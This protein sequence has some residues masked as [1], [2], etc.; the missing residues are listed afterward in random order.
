MDLTR[1]AVKGTGGHQIGRGARSHQGLQESNLFTSHLSSVSFDSLLIAANLIETC[2]EQMKHIHAQLNLDSL[3]PGK[4]FQRKKDD[5]LS[6]ELKLVMQLLRNCFFQNENC[7]AAALGTH[8]I[9][10]LHSLWPWL[11]MDDSL[12]QTA[13]HLLCVYT[14]NYPSGCGSLC[15]SSSGLSPLQTA[16]RTAAGNSLM[17][18]IVK[19]ASQT[20]AENSVIQ[21]MTFNLLANL[22][23]SH[24]CKGILQKNNF[25]QNF[26]SVSLPKGGNKSL[27]SL[28]VAWLKLLLNLSFG[29]DGQ[30]MIVKLNGSLDQLIEM[31][32]FK[33]RSNPN[34]I[35]LIVHNICFNPANKPKILANDKAIS[36][37]S[38]CL[39][40]D[41]PAAQRIG[42]SALWALLH[43]YQK[44]SIYF[45]TFSPLVNTFTHKH[46]NF[47]LCIVLHIIPFY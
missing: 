19:L 17:H 15:V 4:A 26:L 32:K 27:G 6:K 29:E 39:E 21:Q 31:A 24:D 34:I 13:L 45:F 44:V 20:P 23:I 37:L 22:V 1:V 12:M 35:L 11:L 14:A 42:A 18:S 41:S 16:Q 33:H 8:L 40:S 36:L 46:C 9:S 10:I 3:R 47:Y 30:Q 25:L 7:K 5:N 28:A 38:D 43:N 2:L